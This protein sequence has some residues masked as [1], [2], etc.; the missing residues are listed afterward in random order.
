[1]TTT[2][3]FHRASDHSVIETANPANLQQ[4]AAHIARRI[5]RGLAD[6]ERRSSRVY[7]HNGLGVVCA[8]LCRAGVWTDILRDDYHQFDDAARKA[9][10]AANLHNDPKKD[11]KP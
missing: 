10:T 2:Y 8:G 7:V 3:S 11:T 6:S 9:R 4:I 5:H 1:M